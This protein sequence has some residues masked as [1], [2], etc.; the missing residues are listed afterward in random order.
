MHE[1]SPT[2]VKEALACGL[3]VVSVDV[4]DVAERI[5]GIEGCY[6]AAPEPAELAATLCLVRQRGRRLDYRFRLEDLSI[7]RVAEKLRQFYEE[8][9]V[10]G[11]GIMESLRIAGRHIPLLRVSH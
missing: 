5:A 11:C 7:T 1:G 4:G 3:P 2:I 9:A 10:R 6:L 8:I